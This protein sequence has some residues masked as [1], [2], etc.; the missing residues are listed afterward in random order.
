M[1]TKVLHGVDLQIKEGEFVSIM[2][3]SGSGKSTLMHILGFLDTLTSGTYTFEK[4]DVSVLDDDQLAQMRNEKV[5]FV[6]QT[7]NLL[8]RTTV[9]DNVALPL[10]YSKGKI[11]AK[12]VTDAIDSVGLSHRTQ[13]FSN[14]LSGGEKQRVAIARALVNNPSVIFA[15]EPTGNL[16]SKSGNHILHILQNLHADGKTIVM[17]THE[18]DTADHGE[19]I[20]RVKDG[21]ILSDERCCASSICQRRR[22]QKITT[23]MQIKDLLR[24]SIKNLTRSKRRSFLTMLGIIIGVMSVV[25]VMS[26]GAGAQSLIIDQVQQQGTDLVAV[27]AGSSDENGPPAQAFGVVITTL[28]EDDMQALLKKNNVPHVKEAAAYISG[29]DVLRWQ[30]N[31][32]NVTFNGTTASYASIE[33]LTMA[34]RTVFS[35]KRKSSRART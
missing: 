6:F 23:A 3:P 28:T 11:H 12:K 8:P 24:M 18:Q 14:Q 21:R 17:V 16:D 30:N 9:F 7:F 27:L 33:Q 26:V 19:R 10:I 35:T 1:V 2:G 20:I 5:G 25:L 22:T 13:H 32:Q 31:E 29:N 34:R 15:D 4:T